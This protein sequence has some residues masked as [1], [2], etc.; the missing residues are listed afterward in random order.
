[1]AIDRTIEPVLGPPPAF[2]MPA[3]ERTRLGNGLEVIALPRRG[4]PIVDVQLVVRTGAT[5]DVAPVAGRAS[6]V[7][8]MLDEGSAGRGSLEIADA[9]DFLGAELAAEAEWDATVVSLHVLSGRLDAALDLLGDVVVRPAFADTEV[10]RV[11]QERIADLLQDAD[12]PRVVAGIELSRAIYGRGHPY[13]HPIDG[14]RASI[15]A[16][17]RGALVDFHD[18]HYRPANAFLV[19]A[20][21][22]ALD[23]LVPALER[24]FAHWPDRAVS[25]ARPTEALPAA[26]RG[27][28]LVHR[29]DAPQSELRIGHAAPAHPSPDHFAMVVLNTILGG[30][31]TS[32]LNM[33][34][35]EEKG[36]TYG[37]RSGFALR[38]LGGPFVVSTA[39][40]TADTIEAI[41]DAL[42]VVTRIREEPVPPDELDRARNYIALGMPRALETAESL[43][44]HVADIA[45]YGLGEDWLDHYVERVLDVTAADV[46]EAARQRLDPAHARIV[47]V[48]DRD[49]I[50]GPL[51][52]F[53]DGR[54]EHVRFEP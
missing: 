54:I 29:K 44:D 50:G 45:L 47:V 11:R 24:A 30:S 33:K 52:A 6:L 2:R 27:V 51:G 9:V 8:E 42:E 1:M 21:D 32:R 20:G 22:I 39:V 16:L 53:A 41:G 25:A 48:G 46:L 35:R 13:G 10:E 12:E 40:A 43:A 3:V 49:R 17:S 14:T 18:L 28:R 19:A 5:A 15:S 37:A 7:A 38:R 34:L 26:R 31:F 23:T 36:F 4:L